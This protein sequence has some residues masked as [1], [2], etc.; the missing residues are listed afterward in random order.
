MKKMKYEAPQAR[1][2]SGVGASGQDPLYLCN[3]GAFAS[4]DPC[5]GGFEAGLMLC[6]AGITPDVVPGPTCTSGTGPA[7]E[8]CITGSGPQAGG[9]CLSGF[10]V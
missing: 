2:L 10:T 9:Q 5:T 4:P 6:T 7:S 3:P 1:D 8:E